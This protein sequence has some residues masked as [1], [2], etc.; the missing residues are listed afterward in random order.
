MARMATGDS[1]EAL[2]LVQDAML[3]LVKNYSARPEDE[4]APLF[5]RILQSRIRDWYRRLRVRRRF[6][7]WFGSSE[8]ADA[9]D[10]LEQ[11]AAVAHPTVDE[12]AH[13]AETVAALEAAVHKL[14]V[15]QQQAFLLRGWEGLDVAQTARAM[16]C[17]EGS[18]KTHYFRAVRALRDALRDYWL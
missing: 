3:R 18:V 15:R 16:R 11:H 13:T 2:D 17:S 7:V 5:Q 1:D 10:P 4:W 8:D 12:Q 6:Q 14:P 9:A